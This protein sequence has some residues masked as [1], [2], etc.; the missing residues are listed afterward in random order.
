[1]RMLTICRLT[2]SWASAFDRR[3][4][5]RAFI[6]LVLCTSFWGSGV[7]A[8]NLAWAPQQRINGVGSSNGPSLAVFANR[9][10]AAWKG[11]NG[12]QGI[13]WSSFDGGPGRLNR[14]SMGSA[15]PWPL[16]GG[17][18]RPA[19]CRLEGRRHADRE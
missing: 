2:A 11:A 14:T 16:L 9:L 12:D 18:C 5:S 10:F 8:Q 3:L 1:M 17:V 19:L 15:P 6:A 7:S 13:Y 4:V